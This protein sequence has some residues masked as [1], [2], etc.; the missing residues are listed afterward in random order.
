M[1]DQILVY[2]PVTQQKKKNCDVFA[3]EPSYFNLP[4]LSQN[5]NYNRIQNKVSII[6]LPLSDKI[7]HSTFNMSDITEGGALSSFSS[8]KGY[9]GK[10]IKKNFYYKTF[11]TSIDKFLSQYRLKSP[12]YL[13]IDVDGI[14][15]LV[16][17]GGSKS[18]LKCKSILIE[19]NL[20]YKSQ[21]KLIKQILEKKNFKIKHETR[22]ISDENS[23]FYQSFN[24]I[25]IKK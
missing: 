23:K 20:K 3:F 4:I 14:D 1:L 9:D 15:H 8:L 11:G 22:L 7:S 10:N 18:I 16:L 21:Y 17:K 2:I 24:Q 12:D 13:K 19:I 25:W 6:P 5:I